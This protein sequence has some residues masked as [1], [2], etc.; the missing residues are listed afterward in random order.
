MHSK[1]DPS[2]DLNSEL[3]SFLESV[4]SPTVANAIELM[5]LRDRTEGFLSGEIRCVFPDLKPMV[6]L[7][8]TV[9]MS[10]TPGPVASRE[11]YWALWEALEQRKEPSI[12]VIQDVS[13]TPERVAYAG[14]MMSRIAQK[15]GAR[16]IVT[17]AGLRDIAE[18]RDLGVHYFMRY[19]VVSHG[20]FEVVTVNEEIV[21]GGEPIHPGD[22]LHGDQNGIVI[23][24]EKSLAEIQTLVESIRTREAEDMDYISS[25]SFNLESFRNKAHYGKED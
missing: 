13:G 14:E 5:E 9:Q 25:P 12:I 20:N 19:P 10:S 16:G 18:V 24:P 22:I 8:L 15:L 2:L 4:D 7:A 1:S 3:L 17:D 6:G 23:V 21:I 11:G